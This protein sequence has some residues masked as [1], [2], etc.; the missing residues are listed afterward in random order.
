M[1]YKFTLFRM[2]SNKFG[3]LNAKVGFV[4][5][6]IEE[7]EEMDRKFHPTNTCGKIF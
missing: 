2:I 5:H 3:N 7:I 4:H 1:E 6:W